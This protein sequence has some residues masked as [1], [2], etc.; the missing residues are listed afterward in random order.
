MASA[1]ARLWAGVA[2]L[3]A[4]VALLWRT[5]TPE[6]E[7][8][9][10]LSLV[11]LPFAGSDGPGP[12]RDVLPAAVTEALTIALSRLH[13]STVISSASA[14]TFR[15]RPIDVREVGRELKVRYVLQESVLGRGDA[16]RI[17]AR[18]L[19]AADGRVLWSDQFDTR[20]GDLLATQEQPGLPRLRRAVQER[21]AP[22]RHARTLTRRSRSP[23]GLA[24]PDDAPKQPAQGAAADL[25][26]GRDWRTEA[27]GACTAGARIGRRN[28][29]WPASAQAGAHMPAT[30]A[31]DNVIATAAPPDT[32][33]LSAHTRSRSNH[34]ER[35]AR[36]PR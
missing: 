28:R 20:R 10:R 5:A 25:S 29:P 19:D 30:R 4:A 23:G 14:G 33:R 27:A 32:I 13:G 6:P 26:A 36:R 3:V 31:D 35:S 11:V 18:L 15:S 9:A 21:P 2:L 7:P 12:A 1:P 16:V 22:R 24:E 8:P 34:A 17:A